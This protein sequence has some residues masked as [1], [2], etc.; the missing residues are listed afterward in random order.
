[1]QYI[2]DLNVFLCIC[3]TVFNILLQ[4]FLRELIS[5]AS[6]AL[7]KIR[8][9]SLTDENALSGNEELTVKIKVRYHLGFFHNSFKGAFSLFGVL[10]VVA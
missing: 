4:I 3:L 9:M 7:D 2:D 10:F 1:M 6:D 5:N 8:L